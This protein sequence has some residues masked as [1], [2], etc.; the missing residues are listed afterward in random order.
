MY[1]P[2]AC[3]PP[4]LMGIWRRLIFLA[5][6]RKALSGFLLFIAGPSLGSLVL[7]VSFLGVAVC[8]ASSLSYLAMCKQQKV[9]TGSRPGSGP[10]HALYIFGD[11]DRDYFQHFIHFLVRKW[12][13][14]I[15]K[16][17]T[18]SLES[19]KI[20]RDHCSCTWLLLGHLSCTCLLS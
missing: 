13:K 17:L 19:P 5:C 15:F 9:R 12:L 18:I 10:A 8:A 20:V 11:R 2:G 4:L 7:Y 16:V 1:F 6:S 14:S 3:F